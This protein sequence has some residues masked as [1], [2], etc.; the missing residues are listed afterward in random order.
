MNA[1]DVWNGFTVNGKRKCE[2]N[3][4]SCL[5][6]GEYAVILNGDRKKYVCGCEE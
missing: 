1:R 3:D 2:R 6:Y 5:R 4:Y